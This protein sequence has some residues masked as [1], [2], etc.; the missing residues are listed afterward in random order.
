V[1]SIPHNLLLDPEG[2]IIEKN[3]RG[4]DLQKKLAEIYK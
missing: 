2:I 4:E 1:R 3:L